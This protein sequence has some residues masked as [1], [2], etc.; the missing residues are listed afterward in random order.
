MAM[1]DIG[2]VAGLPEVRANPAAVPPA[3]K[4]ATVA[5]TVTAANLLP[6]KRLPSSIAVP[7]PSR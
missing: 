2:G 3:L 4:A 7:V 5:T 1:E 6:A